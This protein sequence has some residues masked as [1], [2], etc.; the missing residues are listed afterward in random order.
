LFERDVRAIAAPLST[1]STAVPAV[2]Q[3]K[4]VGI[5]AVIFVQEILDAPENFASLRQN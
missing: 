2:A 5:E 3:E 1:I 4:H